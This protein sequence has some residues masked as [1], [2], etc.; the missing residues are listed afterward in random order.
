MEFDKGFLSPHFIT[1]PREMHTEFENPL[2]LIHEKKLSTV[3]EIIP[4]LE[5]VAD[6]DATLLSLEEHLQGP[7]TS[8]RASAHGK[9][10]HP[11]QIGAVAGVDLDLGAGL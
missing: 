5:Q 7:L 10:V 6:V 4:L 8:L 1:D 11:A 2:I 9:L 3:K